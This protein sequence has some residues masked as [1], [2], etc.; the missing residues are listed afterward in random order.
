MLVMIFVLELLVQGDIKFK[1]FADVRSSKPWFN[2]YNRV[3]KDRLFLIF[4][5]MWPRKTFIVFKDHDI[6]CE[7]KSYKLKLLRKLVVQQ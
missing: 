2:T 7:P 1:C 3:N 6:H 5:K 4:Y